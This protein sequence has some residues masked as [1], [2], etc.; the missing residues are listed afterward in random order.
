MGTKDQKI[1][2]IK[3]EISESD[4]KRRMD[5]KFLFVMTALTIISSFIFLF[6]FSKY[7]ALMAV[8]AFI[9]GASVAHYLNEKIKYEKGIPMESYNIDEKGIQ[10]NM[11]RFGKKELYMWSEISRYHIADRNLTNL[12]GFFFD[13][14]GRKIIIYINSHK[15]I[16][17]SV[18]SKED[19]EKVLGELSKRIGK[20]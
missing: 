1:E 7:V 4:I 15:K 2:A 3:W 17:L 10:I 8:I 9:T 14:L 5:Q 16:A 6:I 12:M 18:R 20:K 13:I 11:P 19:Y